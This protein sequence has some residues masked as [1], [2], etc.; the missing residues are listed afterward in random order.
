MHNF[1]FMGS[2]SDTIPCRPFMHGI[3]S[4]LQ[5]SSYGIE[6]VPTKQMTRS[7]TKTALKKLWLE[8]WVKI[9]DEVRFNSLGPSDA[10]MC[11]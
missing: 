3:Y 5:M 1:A 9:P 10:Y 4:P 7:L 11:R 8:V 6:G 2:E